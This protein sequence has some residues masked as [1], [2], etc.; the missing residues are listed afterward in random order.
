M[1]SAPGRD[2]ESLIAEHRYNMLNFLASA[3]QK[4]LNVEDVQTWPGVS[5]LVERLTDIFDGTTPH[6]AI[7]TYPEAIRVLEE[8]GLLLQDAWFALGGVLGPWACLLEVQSW[9]QDAVQAINPVIANL[10][11]V[12]A[13]RD[14]YH[15]F[16]QQD[17]QNAAQAL[18]EMVKQVRLADLLIAAGVSYEDALEIEARSKPIEQDENV[19]RL[20][21]VVPDKDITI[22]LQKNREDLIKLKEEKPVTGAEELVQPHTQG[23]PDG[24]KQE[25][26]SGQ[27]ENGTWQGFD[28][29]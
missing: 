2:Y 29:N 16:N 28:K 15:G 25:R 9:I 24:E 22:T 18:F 13:Q 11:I 21:N 26:D 4:P 1:G 7:L 20:K 14:A 19:S 23:T 17:F 10:I 8:N 12:T 6:P 5:T 27:T 3:S